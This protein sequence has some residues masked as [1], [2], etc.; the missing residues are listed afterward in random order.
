M[1]WCADSLTVP[2]QLVSDLAQREFA[3]VLR[4][5][6]G[7]IAFIWNMEDR[8]SAAWVGKVRDLYGPSLSQWP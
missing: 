8:D 1:R 3:R 6:T 5:E 4:P 2:S 7:M